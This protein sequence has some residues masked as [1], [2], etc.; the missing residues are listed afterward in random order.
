MTGSPWF[1]TDAGTRSA[2]FVHNPDGD[3]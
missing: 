1:F 3:S 2:A